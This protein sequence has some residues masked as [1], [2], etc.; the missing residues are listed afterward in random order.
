MSDEPRQGGPRGTLFVV[1]TP[2]GNLDDMTYR[3]VQVLRSVPV[4]LAEDTRRAAKL[5][6]RYDCRPRVVSLH[7]HNLR[8]RL[9]QLLSLLMAGQDLA[10]VSDAG[11]PAVSDPGGELV[12]EAWRAGVPVVPVPGVSAVTSV[13]SVAGFPAERFVFAGFVPKKPGQR[14]RCWEW[15]DASGETAVLFETPHRIDRTLAEMAGRW[16]GRRACLARELTKV[17]EELIRGTLTDIAEK[18]RGRR[19]RGEITLALEPRGENQRGRE[20]AHDV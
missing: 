14:E 1:A 11:T 18:T 15:I 10:L 16:P 6:A 7:A 8:E 19:W 12:A 13:L 17:H 5:L 2:I 3:G 9:P 4:V 20:A